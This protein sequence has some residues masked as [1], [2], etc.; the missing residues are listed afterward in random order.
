[1][2]GFR[3]DLNSE[4]PVPVTELRALHARNDADLRAVADRTGARLLDVFPDVCGSGETCSAFFGA[5]EPKFTD[6]AHLRPLF[7]RHHVHFLDFLLTGPP[8][9]D[10]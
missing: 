8:G 5:R 7:V 2:T 9:P 3:V 1:M 10:R 6:G 4:N